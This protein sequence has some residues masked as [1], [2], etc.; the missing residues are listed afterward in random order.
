MFVILFVKLLHVGIIKV[1]EVGEGS[2]YETSYIG[3]GGEVGRVG[4]YY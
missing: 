4:T 3:E 2:G 1:A